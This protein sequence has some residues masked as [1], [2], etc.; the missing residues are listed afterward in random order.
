MSGMVNT[1]AKNHFEVNLNFHPIR[2]IRFR[3]SDPDLPVEK[4]MSECNYSF[5]RSLNGDKI[6]SFKTKLVIMYIFRAF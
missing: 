2:V 3:N 1:I 6:F 5:E 4:E